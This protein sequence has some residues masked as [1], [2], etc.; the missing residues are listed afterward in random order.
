MQSEA[1][2][3]VDL[4]KAGNGLLLNRGVRFGNVWKPR[5]PPVAVCSPCGPVLKERVSD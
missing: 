3:N 2:G 5:A 4:G 1:L